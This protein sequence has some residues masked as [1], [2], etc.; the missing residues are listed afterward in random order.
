MRIYANISRAGRLGVV[1]KMSA[2]GLHFCKL[3]KKMT[4]IA[5]LPH[6]PLGLER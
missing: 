2:H 6:R 1:Y 4:G 3:V 5:A